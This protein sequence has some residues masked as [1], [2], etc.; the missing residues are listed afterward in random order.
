[1]RLKLY[2]ALHV[3]IAF[4]MR[5]DG[6]E[7]PRLHRT[8]SPSL[9]QRQLLREKHHEAIASERTTS[10]LQTKS[11]GTITSRR[12]SARLETD[13]V[14][15]RGRH[16]EKDK[17]RMHAWLQDG[18]AVTSR[19]K[20]SRQHEQPQQ[21]YIFFERDRAGF[22][23]IKL[24]LQ[25]MV[26]IAAITGRT[27]VLP[28]PAHEDHLKEAYYEFDFFDAAN[29]SKAIS[30][31][32]AR[33]PGPDVLRVD[34]PLAEVD[35]RKL[36][37]S[38]DWLF[39]EGESRI[40]HFECLNLNARDQAIAAHAVLHG[41]TYDH[42]LQEMASSNLE[43]LGFSADANNPDFDC[44]H[45]RRGDF[46]SFAKQF[47][48]TDQELSAIF[49]EK[50][51]SKRVVLVVSDERP[52]LDLGRTIRYADDSY[53]K[54]VSMQTRI[55][56]DMLMCSRAK[57]FVGSPLSTFTNGIEELRRGHA[58]LVS[59]APPATM[60]YAGDPE[61]NANGLCWNKQTTFEG[62]KGCDKGAAACFTDMGSPF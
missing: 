54:D 27:L 45:V 39:P 9:I 1:M 29:L 34:K 12:T 23:N 55:A 38:K 49:K 47:V 52:A 4:A 15:V 33:E 16:S 42:H 31:T 17:R 19:Q 7:M 26:A 18:R 37:G 40:Q 58:A 5:P 59:L 50:L 10:L 41:C 28:P 14:A 24:Q 13:V 20:P 35:I 43:K 44:V 53:A 32:L 62:L 6:E 60:L 48:K 21:H 3:S 11:I 56:V 51:K 25:S 61:F 8:M 30:V 2:I 22:N 36:D 57:D 46:K